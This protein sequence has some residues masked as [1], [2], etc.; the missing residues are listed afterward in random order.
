MRRFHKSS[1]DWAS[2]AARALCLAVVAALFVLPSGCKSEA[3]NRKPA[4]QPAVAAE[5]DFVHA[6]NAVDELCHCWKQKDLLYGKQW[7][8]ANLRRQ[9]TDREIQDAI[10]GGR[11]QHLAYQVLRGERLNSGRFEFQV[12]LYKKYEGSQDDKLETT[13]ARVV[14]GM[15]EDGRWRVADFPIPTSDEKKSGGVPVPEIPQ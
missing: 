2:S 11:I 1:K 13:Q 5:E 7:F 15:D 3:Q 8:C 9:Y 6:L 14:A 4:S 12:L 10:I